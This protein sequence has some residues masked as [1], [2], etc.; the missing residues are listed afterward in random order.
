MRVSWDI[1]RLLISNVPA[2][3][4]AERG[5]SAVQSPIRARRSKC[6]LHLRP[7]TD[8]IGAGRKQ[9]SEQVFYRAICISAFT[10]PDSTM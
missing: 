5:L 4:L 1:A 8:A 10:M 7:L 3:A 2:L 6:E 9:K